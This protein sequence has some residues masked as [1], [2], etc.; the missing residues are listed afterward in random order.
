MPLFQSSSSFIAA[1]SVVVVVAILFG[2]LLDD[3]I[4]DVLKNSAKYLALDT[5]NYVSEHLD[6]DSWVIVAI[7]IYGI[8]ATIISVIAAWYYFSAWYYLSVILRV[9]WYYFSVIV[10]NV[11][12]LII[13]V[14]WYYL[15]EMA[16]PVRVRVLD[17]GDGGANRNDNGDVRA[18]ANRNDNG[19]VKVKFLIP[20]VRQIENSLRG[21][22]L[23]CPL[24]NVTTDSSDVTKSLKNHNCIHIET[25]NH[26]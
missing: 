25:G 17:N 7:F 26:T 22:L 16:V 3:D 12:Y 2:F 11:W 10:R 4:K 20:S 8:L 9:A 14:A 15:M 1:A 24:T 5:A 21:I 6:V 18:G 23:F 13:R 19:D